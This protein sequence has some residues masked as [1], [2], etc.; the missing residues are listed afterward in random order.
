[1]SVKHNESITSSPSEVNSII[2]EQFI[3]YSACAYLENTW[4]I[5]LEY[6]FQVIYIE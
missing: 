1:M 3:E 6:L 4:K 5:Y 2:K